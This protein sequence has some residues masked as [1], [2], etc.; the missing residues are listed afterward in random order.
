MK[1]IDAHLHF[2][3]NENFNQL[4]IRVGHEN[5]AEH[6]REYFKKENIVHAII[7][8]LSFWKSMDYGCSSSHR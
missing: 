4:A 8:Y 7:C 2:D 5:T 1:I 3:R 6:I